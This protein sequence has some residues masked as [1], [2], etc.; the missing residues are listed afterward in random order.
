MY[1]GNSWKQQSQRNAFRSGFPAPGEGLQ[2]TGYVSDCSDSA[3]EV[4][5][6]LTQH[7]HPR[8]SNTAANFGSWQGAPKRPRPL[9]PRNVFAP[10]INNRTQARFKP[11]V[12][13]R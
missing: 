5:N 6:L 12:P 11:A 10:P 3:N 7:P 1:P 13:P 9:Q 2:R 8:L 4:E